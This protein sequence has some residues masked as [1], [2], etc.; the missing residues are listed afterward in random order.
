M[1]VHMREAYQ[2]PHTATQSPVY[3][4]ILWL[5]YSSHV[6]VYMDSPGTRHRHILLL[7][8]PIILCSDAHTNNNYALFSYLLCSTLCYITTDSQ[9]LGRGL[10]WTLQVLLN[11]KGV[12]HFR[13]S[14]KETVFSIPDVDLCDWYS[15]KLPLWQ[16]I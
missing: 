16:C 9:T 15:V 6:V 10:Q 3:I 13:L 5:W 7:I 14:S 11:T 1:H 2:S 12:G 8:L 4:I